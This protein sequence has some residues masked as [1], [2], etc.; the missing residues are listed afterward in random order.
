MSNSRNPDWNETY[1][2]NYEGYVTRHEWVSE[3]PLSET[4]LSLFDSMPEVSVVDGVPLEKT[5][6][7][8]AIDALFP[9]ERTDRELSLS[10]RYDGCEVTIESD[11]TII[12]RPLQSVW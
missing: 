9:R 1:G 10:F 3:Q 8:D 11:G 4:L 2:A 12:A 5:V 7:V 6:D